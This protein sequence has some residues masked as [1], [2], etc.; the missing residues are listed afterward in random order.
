MLEKADYFAL[1]HPKSKYSG[2]SDGKP[3]PVTFC[4]AK[5]G[6]QWLGNNNQYRDQ[7]LILLYPIE[8]PTTPYEPCRIYTMDEV[9]QEG[10]SWEEKINKCNWFAKVPH[11]NYLKTTFHY[12]DRN[13][14]Q[15]SEKDIE[16][17]HAA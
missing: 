4:P 8:D 10:P 3:F 17:L 1:I 16:R 15:L 13:G 11:R 9:I 12:V 5:D 2:Q 7:D 14:R 6:Y